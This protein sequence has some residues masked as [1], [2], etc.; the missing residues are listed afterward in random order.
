MAR[1]RV[2]L[3]PVVSA[4]VLPVV[5]SAAGTRRAPHTP[6]PPVGTRT[7]GLPAGDRSATTPMEEQQG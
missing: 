3:P 5:A 6:V 2:T 7:G 1:Q 4:P